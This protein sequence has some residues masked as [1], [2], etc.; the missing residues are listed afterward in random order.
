MPP[1][2]LLPAV[3]ALILAGL[4]GLLIRPPAPVVAQPVP[5][6]IPG[7]LVVLRDDPLAPPARTR[8]GPPPVNRGQRAGSTFIV[9]YDAGFQA[10]PT[11]MAAFQY[12]VDIWAAHLSSPVPIV[13]DASFAPL[14]TGVLGQAGP[15]VFFR[16][17]TGAPRAGT[18]YPVAI[19]NRLAGADLAPGTADVTAT[20]SSTFNFYFGTDGNPATNQHDFVSIVMHELGHGLGFLG[21]ANSPEAG[22]GAWGLSP[23]GQTQRPTI[24]DTFVVTGA[25]QSII[26]TST[27]PNPSGALLAQY[28]GGNL[29]FS[30]P[31]TNAAAGG[32][33]RLYAPGTFSPGSSYSHL[34]EA[35]YG[36]GN[37]NSL[38]TPMLAA[39]EAIHSPGPIALGMLADSGW[40]ATP[41][42]SGT[43]QPSGTPTPAPTTTPAPTATP[44]PLSNDAF[45]GATLLTDI[46]STPA[47]RTQSTAAFTSEA[48]DPALACGSTARPPQS[49]TAWFRLPAGRSGFLTV[50]TDGSAYDTVVGVF[51]GAALGALTLLACDD[52]SGEGA[53]SAIT[54]L[55]LP[56]LLLNQSYY[57]VVAAKGTSAGG[58]LRLTY[59]LTT[60]AVSPTPT[61]AATATPTPAPAGGILR[62]APT[63]ARVAPGGQVTTT[64]ETVIPAAGLG[65]WT[66][67]IGYNAAAVQPVGCTVQVGG[68]TALCNLTPVGA[69][70][71]VRV[72]GSAFPGLTGTV[73]LASVVFQAT[74][75]VTTSTLTL[76]APTY[77]DPGGAPLP[78]T[79]Q[80][81]QVVPAPNAPD[82]TLNGTVDAVDALCVLRDVAG[83]PATSACASPLPFGDVNGSGA[84]DAVDA[85][86][87]LRYVA[88][89][90]ATISC[91]FTAGVGVTVPADA[92]APPAPPRPGAGAR[93][94]GGR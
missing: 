50:T 40:T 6:S 66:V 56:P 73:A 68:A 81:G 60:T 61:P 86:C 47:S 25:G 8:V 31:N 80:N 82:V 83:L 20:F 46:G 23:P 69:P 19:A 91:P 85:L 55:Q 54:N 89:L 72:T 39:G 26:N 38:M 24:Y 5:V 62:L 87:V 37:P 63:P 75:S 52:D 43:P 78:V 48:G 1:R 67:D 71:T 77:T 18:F 27:F 42:P 16:D 35:T 13:V 94:D 33:P 4:C 70:A 36:R 41:A 32:A 22:V 58:A 65:S 21:S 74:P 84:V 7:T 53:R 92:T 88:G 49:A 34:D 45:A 10:N 11:A 17:F 57:I 29:F 90:P 12:A 44:A 30:G 93:P 59:Q 15:G 9:N 64:L 79:V 3:A 28:T 2:R 76:S 14:A 51:R